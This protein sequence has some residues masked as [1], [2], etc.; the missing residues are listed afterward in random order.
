[1]N[2]SAKPSVMLKGVSV[3]QGIAQGAAWVLDE[4]APLTIPRRTIVEAEVAAEMAR[5]DAAL[6]E[7]ESCLRGAQKEIERKVGA[8]EARIFEAQILLLRDPGFAKQVADCCSTGKINVEAAVA[9]TVEKLSARFAALGNAILRER[10]AD[11]RDVG[12]RIVE[13]LLTHQC[14][15]CSDLPQ[16][17]IVVTNELFPSTTARMNFQAV[18]GVITERGG[19]TSHASILTRSLGIPGLIGI[20]DAAQRIRNGDA[21]IV[22]GLAGMV[23][24]NPS[25]EVR[26]EY[27]RL[28]ADF[29]AHRNSLQQLLD[30]PTAT[31]DGVAVKLSANIGK[32]A[33]A[34]AAA[35]FRA[36]GVGLYRT[37]IKA[38]VD[39]AR[40]AGKEI[41]ICGEM[42]GNA[43]YTE[44]LLGLG[45]RS[46]STTPGEILEVKKAIRS[47]RISTAEELAE[48]V[49]NLRTVQE[50]KACV[51][52]GTGVSPV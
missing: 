11:V 47:V 20:K 27:D 6:D 25:P 30:G 28:Q 22:D 36:D 3:S 46:F 35:L 40:A 17:S 9:D 1:M 29:T 23:H 13:R 10:T 26:R 24:V 15:R 48:Q 49:L 31:A 16:G 18:S 21:L 7:A 4:K 2:A 33:D 14:Q 41:S 43:A 45:V 8:D 5:F 52:S 42:A 12:R 37:A 38:V 19:R 51:S 39:A 50:I 44:L 32:I 34:A